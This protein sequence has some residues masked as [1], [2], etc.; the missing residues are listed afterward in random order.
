MT[1]VGYGDK[2]PKSFHTKIFS[3]M[4]ILFGIATF[5]LITAQL[6]YEITDVHTKSHPIIPGEEIKELSKFPGE[7]GLFCRAGNGIR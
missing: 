6:S 1:T 4:W 2:V 7:N 5:S 3:M